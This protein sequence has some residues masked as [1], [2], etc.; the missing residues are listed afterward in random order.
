MTLEEM[1]RDYEKRGEKRGMRRGEKRGMRRGEKRGIIRGE[2][3]LQ[4]LMASMIEAGEAAMLPK[5]AQNGEFL[6][7]MYKKYHI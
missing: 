5:L 6:Q 3:R 1:F 2:Q 7:Q 4:K